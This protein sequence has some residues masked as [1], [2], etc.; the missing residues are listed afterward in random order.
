MNV[1]VEPPVIEFNNNSTFHYGGSTEEQIIGF[2][3]LIFGCL[4]FGTM[5]LPLKRFDCGDGWLIIYMHAFKCPFEGF[6][7]S[8]LNVLAFSFMALSYW[9]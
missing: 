4:C 7:F 6:L 3:V 9:L 1:S 5:F 2:A 8:L